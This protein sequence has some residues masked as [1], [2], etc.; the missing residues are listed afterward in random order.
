MAQATRQNWLHK[1]NKTLEDEFELSKKK[2]A[3]LQKQLETNRQQH[4]G[5]LK[6]NRN[7]FAKL[8]QQLDAQKAEFE[9]DVVEWKKKYE[10]KVAEAEKLLKKPDSLAGEMT[11]SKEQLAAIGAEN[12]SLKQQIE[13]LKT[14]IDKELV[15]KKQ[16]ETKVAGD[17]KRWT[18]ELAELSLIHI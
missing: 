2:N 11:K 10:L 7:Q 8:K 14:N 3:E 12:E 6:E 4:E 1:T 18:T 13:K 5:Q 17:S 9:G 16:L 15:E